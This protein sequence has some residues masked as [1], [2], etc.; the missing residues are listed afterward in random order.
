MAVI[1]K[2]RKTFSVVYR[3]KEK[4]EKSNP[5]W[6]TYFDYSSALKRKLEIEKQ[7]DY[8]IENITTHTKII[9]YL[10]YFANSKGIEIWSPTRYQS[11]VGIIHNYIAKVVDNKKIKDVDRKFADKIFSAL[12]VMPAL[13]KRNQVAEET[14]PISML[15]S[16]NTILKGSFDYLVANKIIDDN[17]FMYINI[18]RKPKKITSDWNLDDVQCL[19]QHCED[20][21]L[22]VFLH[23]LFSTGFGIYEVLGLTWSDLHI[24][25]YC[26]Y[27]K[28]CYIESF[29]TLRRLNKNTVNQL[30]ENLIIKRFRNFS[31]SNTNTEVI[32]MK[33]KEGSRKVYIPIKIAMLLKEWRNYQASMVYEN[34]EDL[35]FTLKDGRPYDDRV[36][37][38]A[39]QKTMKQAL[40]SELTLVKLKNYGQ[41]Q[42]DEKN[43]YSN[44][45]YGGLVEPLQLPQQKDDF[46]LIMKQKKSSEIR[47]I[48]TESLN[49]E[50]GMMNDLIGAIN[51]DFDL[52]Q[53]LLNK[54]LEK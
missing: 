1:I 43:T 38:N 36:M 40:L 51:D 21:K 7:S 14:I 30:D 2:Q 45:Y 31:F 47:K 22:Y 54:L 16:C 13:G 44:L 48:F 32:L 46:R 53:E 39:F 4:D 42:T 49:L 26:L 27:E 50:K 17:P 29:N 12:E 6:E 9:D 52:K 24:E 20:T 10:Q 3:H 8:S 23:T 35:V 5:I 41:K 25:E 15:R 34:T 18:A 19:F 33:K 37:K 11:N 28:K